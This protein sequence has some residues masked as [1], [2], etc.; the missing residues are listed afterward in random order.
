MPHPTDNLHC[1]HCDGKRFT[2]D[3]SD[4][5]TITDDGVDVSTVDCLTCGAIDLLPTDLIPGHVVP[6]GD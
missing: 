3:P 2:A 6:M 4:A 1:P 5:V